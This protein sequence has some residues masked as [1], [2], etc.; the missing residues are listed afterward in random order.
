MFVHEM[1]RNRQKGFFVFL[2]T[3]YG[4]V[5][6]EHCNKKKKYRLSSC[7]VSIG[8]PCLARQISF[9]EKKKKKKNGTHT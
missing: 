7:G 5:K 4:T 2:S 6:K 3:K 8:H 9:R 1:K